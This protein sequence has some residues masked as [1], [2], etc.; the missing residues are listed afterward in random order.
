[1][2]KAKRFYQAELHKSITRQQVCGSV[3]K[4][5]SDALR[6]LLNEA[7]QRVEDNHEH[8]IN[9]ASNEH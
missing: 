6:A 7:K 1:M 4:R 3:T 2:P 9:G 5:G 8:G